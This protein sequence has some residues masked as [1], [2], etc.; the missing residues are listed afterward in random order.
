MTL[1]CLVVNLVNDWS[2]CFLIKINYCFQYFQYKFSRCSYM[3]GLGRLVRT[4]TGRGFCHLL[5]NA[6]HAGR[7]KCDP[8]YG[9]GVRIDLGTSNVGRR[10]CV[11]RMVNRIGY[12]VPLLL[13]KTSNRVPTQPVRG[14]NVSSR[15]AERRRALRPKRSYSDNALAADADLSNLQFFFS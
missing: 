12:P 1:P 13:A 5:A 15:L 4:T 8:T 7:A 6:A 3:C 10:L 2:R 14:S 11:R 9:F